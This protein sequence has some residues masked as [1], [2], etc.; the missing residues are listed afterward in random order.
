VTRPAPS[1]LA[2]SSA[3]VTAAAGRAQPPTTGDGRAHAAQGWARQRWSHWR[4]WLAV[5][6]IVGMGAILVAL[7]HAPAP[8]E[9]LSPNSVGPTGTHA[10]ADIL[11]RLGRRV[12]TVTTVSSAIAAAPAGATLV[13]TSPGI[14]SAGELSTL[15]RVPAN[16]LVV[17]PS[18]A[19]LAALTPG[20]VPVGRPQ[21]VAPRQ[22]RCTLRA[23]VLAGAVDAGGQSMR[24]G[25]LIS[26]PQL[27][28][29]SAAG[30]TLLQLQLGGRLVTIMGAGATL[31]NA[32]LARQGNAALAI[33]LLPTR[34]IVWLVPSPLAAAAG[35]PTSSSS[36][37]PKSFWDLLPLLAYLVAAQLAF[38][39]L[40]A[41]GWRARRLGPLVTE[42]LPVVVVAAETV[43]GH[44]R[45]YQ[46]RRARGKAAAALRGS[47]LARLGPAL[48]LPASPSSEAVTGA[49]AQRST[50][51]PD[52]IGSLLYGPAPR[53]DAALVTL[54]RDLDDL[55]REVGLT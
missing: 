24:S 37:S 45:L 31:T 36:G 8:A 22:P 14:L 46:A 13:I 7:A 26:A 2:D 32:Y 33:N 5:A 42:P 20:V 44:G 53:T 9:Y 34:R 23:A 47:L 10:L 29:P 27:C 16:L 18:N 41:V 17:G 28:Y 52:R 39:L 3:A 25:P 15:A 38:A 11:A 12:Q 1:V 48:G 40:L 51:S 4:A 35:Q 19:A 55:A 49:V 54:A 6:L 21:P 43:I 30:S 50:L